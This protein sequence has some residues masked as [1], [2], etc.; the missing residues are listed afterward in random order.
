MKYSIKTTKTL[1]TDNGL[2]F[3]VGQDIA[4]ML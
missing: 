2:K 4:F 3:S 1:T